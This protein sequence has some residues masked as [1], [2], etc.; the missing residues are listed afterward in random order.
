MKIAIIGGGISGLAAYLSLKKRLPQ[1]P[2]PQAEHEI[3][4]YEA[5][6]TSTRFANA[7]PT[8]DEAET[9]SATLSVGGGLGLG[10]NGL[11][12][13]RSLDEELFHDV[14]RAGYPYSQAA[15]LSARGFRMMT[16]PM[17]NEEATPMNALMISRN[18]FWNCLRRRVPDGVIINRKIVEIGTASGGMG[19]LRFADGGFDAQANLVLGADGL[20]S[21]ARRSIFRGEDGGDAYPPHYEYV[22]AISDDSAD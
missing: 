22:V 9:Y 20:K 21:V 4:I 13:L 7:A 11:A 19:V 6:E 5:H 16:A 10:P 14:V 2:R 3:T 15:F 12:V 17:R 8:H 1:P 18:E